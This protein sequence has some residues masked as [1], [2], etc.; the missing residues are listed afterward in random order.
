MASPLF[1][2]TGKIA[3]VTGAGRG[4]GA[5]MAK[6]LAKSGARV[7]LAARTDSDLKAV[8]ADITAA[9]GEALCHPFDAGA[10]NAAEELVRAVADAWGALDVMIVNHGIA[11]AEDA[12]DC[13]R[14]G[15]EKTLQINL[16]SAF[17]CCQA[18][19]RQMIAQGRGGSI[20]VTSSTA[21]SVAF[22][23]LASYGAS[24]GGVDQMVRQ[25]AS[26][27][28]EF[29]IRV[30]GIAPGYTTH[31]MRNSRSKS[32]DPEIEEQM[33]LF[34]PLARRGEPEEFGG[35]AVF[36]ASHA[37]SFVTG[38]VLPVDGGYLVR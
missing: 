27:W 17:F 7:A 21:S 34:T 6:E 2:L 19:A 25:L 31:R 22:A 18:A 24:K 5:A 14:E 15:W 32:W 36:L 38:V 16:T 1:D 8:A 3:I 20:V 26:E 11:V 10:E 37:A 28:G 30:N 12:L 35:P 33:K 13:G 29:G 23:G 4:I 9:G